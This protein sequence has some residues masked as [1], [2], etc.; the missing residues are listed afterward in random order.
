MVIS[1][2]F[3]DTPAGMILVEPQTARGKAREE[4]YNGKGR[5]TEEFGLHKRTR[6]QAKGT[7]CSLPDGSWPKA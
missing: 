3:I 4:F 1:T 7:M 2:R 5:D 6:R